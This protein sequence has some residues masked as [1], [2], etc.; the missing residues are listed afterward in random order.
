MGLGDIL[1]GSSTSEPLGTTTTTTT[2]TKAAAFTTS[3][4]GQQVEV[5]SSTGGAPISSIAGS[6]V[7]KDCSANGYTSSECIGDA[8]NWSAANTGELVGARE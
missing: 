6:Q 5:E 2:T 1:D 4:P 3:S 8:K 7:Q